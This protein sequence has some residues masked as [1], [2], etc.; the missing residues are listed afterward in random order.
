MLVEAALDYLKKGFS[1]IPI[2]PDKRPFI[3][4]EKYQKEKASHGEIQRWWRKWPNALIGLVTGKISDLAVVDIDSAEGAKELNRLIPLDAIGPTALTPGGGMHH[5]FRCPDGLGNNTRMIPGCDLRANG[6]YIIA[7]PSGSGNGK[8]YTWMRG[9]SIFEVPLPEL[10]GAYLEAI[11]KQSKQEKAKVSNESAKVSISF[12]K[13][14]RDETLFHIANCLLK[15]GMPA[16]EAEAVLKF[17]A[18][19]CSPAYPEKDVHIK[20]ASA[21]ERINK[22]ERNI[23]SEIRAWVLEAP[24]V[25]STAQLDRELSLL[26]RIDA[27]NRAKILNTLCQ[28]GL[29]ERAGNKRGHYRLV[30]KETAKVDFVNTAEKEIKL[31]WPFGIERF[32]RTL[33]KNI[34]VVAGESDS[35]KTAFLLNFV[36]LNMAGH[37]I[38][39]FSSEMGASELRGRLAKFDMPIES[40]RFHAWERSS[41]FADVIRPDAVNVID[42]LEVHDEFYKVGAWIKQMYD[43][44]KNGVAV[45]A[46]QKNIDRDYGLGGAR[47]VEKARLYLAMEPGKLKIVKAKNWVHDQINPNKMEIAFKLVK[48]CNFMARS[49]WHKP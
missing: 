49:E 6:G 35:G 4:W 31:Q 15:G 32:F 37:E 22:K 5:Y 14:H 11:G 44:L 7:P 13:G 17:L 1:V 12:E 25:F 28:E 23:A 24:G 2:R 46:I 3:R 8:N 34:I 48:G 36:N 21:K 30:D 40:W 20:I 9:L 18:K 26:T 41:D 10:P 19:N 42:F 33:P 16:S 29:I 39:Y 47:S 43:R 45:I 38:H 27:N